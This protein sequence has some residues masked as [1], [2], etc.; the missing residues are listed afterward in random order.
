MPGLLHF[1]LQG[2]WSGLSGGMAMQTLILIWVTC[3]TNWDAEVHTI[4][5]ITLHIC[6]S[7]MCEKGNSCTIFFPLQSNQH[8]LFPINMISFIYTNSLK[9]G[10][11]SET[12]PKVFVNYGQLPS[13]IQ[14]Y[15]YCPYFYYLGNHLGPITQILF[16]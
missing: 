3:R 2:I 12:S 6:V 8:L 10:I 4:H 16:Q 13:S 7:R 9:F 15:T 1:C 5:I 14:N 11:I